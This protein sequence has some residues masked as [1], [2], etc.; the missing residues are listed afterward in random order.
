MTDQLNFDWA[1]VAFASK[2]PLREL[3]ATFIAA[4][5][6]LSAARLKQLIKTYLPSG[7]LVIGL[8]TADYVSGFDGQPQFRTLRGRQI[9]ALLAKVNSASPRKVATLTYP[10]ADEPHIIAKDLFAQ[11]VFVNGSWQHSFHLRPTFYAL[12]KLRARYELVSPFVDETEAKTYLEAI[13]PE[14]KA[15]TPLP[16]PGTEITT[17]AALTLAGVAGRR[18]FDHTFQTGVVLGRPS[19]QNTYAF[20]TAS[21]NAIVPYQTHAMHFGASR[22]QHFSP[23]GDLN[24]YDTNHAEMALLVNATKG[25]ADLSDATMFINLL[26][27]PTCAR[28]LATTDLAE[29]IYQHDHSQ[30]YALQQFAAAGKQ[31]RLT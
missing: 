6:E 11:Y 5:R 13:W 20:I 18:S 14:V 21:W 30:G 29:I 1:D 8:S 19:G 24:H 4:P 7:N 23:P 22:E 15:T 17:A 27:C 26:P 2:K 12:A 25:H 10:P 3:K 16:P 31:V 28:I 9:E